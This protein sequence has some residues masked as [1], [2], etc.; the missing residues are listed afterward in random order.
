MSGL[1]YIFYTVGNS[2]LMFWGLSLWQRYRMVSSLLIAAVIF[3]LVYDNLILALGIWMQEGALLYA[4]SVP[5]FA[6]H[7]LVLPWL[8][9]A[10]FDQ[11]RRAGIGWAQSPR[12]RTAAIIFS[13]LVM[14]AGVLTRMVG[15]TWEPTVMDGVTRYVAEGVVGP[16]LVSL[17]S[18]GFA[19]V[20]GFFLWRKLGWPWLALAGLL[21][22]IGEGVPIEAVKRVLGSGTEVL[23]MA[24]MLF[25]EQRQGKEAA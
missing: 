8:I 13:A 21:V 15:V 4:L 9:L 1:L 14:V 10:A 23:F 17:L 5:R 2:L 7:Q 24:I 25:L 6:L 3:G 12:G 11:G 18:I 22:F 19:T 16:P 20:V